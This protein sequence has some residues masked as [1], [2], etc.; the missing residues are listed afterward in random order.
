MELTAHFYKN[1]AKRVDGPVP[2]PKRIEEMIEESVIVQRFKAF[3]LKNGF[4][5]KRLAIYWHTELGVVL[6]IDEAKGKAVSV[7]SRKCLE[8]RL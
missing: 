5:Y 4:Y 1:W 7:M 6:K 2:E 8:E 3:T